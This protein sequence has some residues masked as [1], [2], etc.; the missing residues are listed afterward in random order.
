M[1]DDLF[2]SAAKNFY[3]NAKE[4]YDEDVQRLLEKKGCG[5][6]QL[7][8]TSLNL[9]VA[10]GKQRSDYCLPKR[11][12]EEQLSLGAE[13]YCNVEYMECDDTEYMN[14]FEQAGYVAYKALDANHRGILCMCKKDYAVESVRMFSDPHMLHL[15]LTKDGKTVEIIVV[16][17][18]VANGGDD[19]YRDRRVQW[20][21]VIDY[22]SSIRKR[23]ENLVVV[24]DFNHGVISEKYSYKPRHFFNFQIVNE[25]L[26]KL[27]MKL[28]AISGTSYRGYQ[29]PDHLFTT[30]GVEVIKADY[31]DLFEDNEI[32]GIPDH[33]LMVSHLIYK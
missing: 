33:K 29:T 14:L 7:V 27:G 20:D 11:V 25:S 8:E 23:S 1:D 22:I 21:R 13:V 18:L 2:R 17:I 4:L 15:A 32:I 5:R 28:V 24:G 26:E 16:R 9:R 3:E 30:S 31:L 6:M 10:N 12:A 19:D